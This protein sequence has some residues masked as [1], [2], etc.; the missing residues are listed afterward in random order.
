MKLHVAAMLMVCKMFG[1]MQIADAVTLGIS[2]D[3]SLF[4]I[5][6]KPVYLVGISYYEAMAIASS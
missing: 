4:T 6:E 1:V 3:G 2:K 5:N